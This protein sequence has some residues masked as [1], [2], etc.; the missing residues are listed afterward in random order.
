MKLIIQ[1]PNGARLVFEDVDPNTATVGDIKE[2]IHDLEPEME[3][4]CQKLIWGGKPMPNHAATLRSL[5]ITEDGTVVYLFCMTQVHVQGDVA[6]RICFRSVGAPPAADFAATPATPSTVVVTS[7]VPA[8]PAWLQSIFDKH[9]CSLDADDKD[10][11]A[12]HLAK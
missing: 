2:R 12:K 10:L 3:P 1:E 7:T 8:V 4:A 11:I 5:G 6:E 9:G